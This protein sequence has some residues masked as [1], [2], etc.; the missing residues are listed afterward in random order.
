MVSIVSILLL[1][2]LRIVLPV[3]RPQTQA[4][5]S[6]QSQASSPAYQLSRYPSFSDQQLVKEVFFSGGHPSIHLSSMTPYSSA[7]RPAAGYGSG[8]DVIQGME[9]QSAAHMMDSTGGYGFVGAGLNPGDGG[10]Q[11]QVYSA[12]GHSGEEARRLGG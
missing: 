3:F 9:V 10:C 2:W 5:P 12:A 6:G 4:L 1:L 8:P 7:V 11:G